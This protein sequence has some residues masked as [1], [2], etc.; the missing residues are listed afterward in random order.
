MPRPGCRCGWTLPDAFRRVL[1]NLMN[2][3][4]RYGKTGLQVRV[5]VERHAVGG[6]APV[7]IDVLDRGPGV[8]DN[9]LARLGRPFYRTDEARACTPG[10]GLGL[11]LVH[12]LAKREGGELTLAL[13]EGGG[14]CA[15]IRLP[16]QTQAQ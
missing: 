5:G 6:D 3:A 2:N 8:S 16:L 11:A 4:V 12:R 9:N 10:T 13:R 7:L 14:F 1:S 15:S